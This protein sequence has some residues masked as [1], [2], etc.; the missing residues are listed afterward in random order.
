MM[1]HYHVRGE[2]PP[3]L[4]LHGLGAASI[5]WR[6]QV[7]DLSAAFQVICPDLRGFGESAIDS[8][9]A[10][11]TV[12]ELTSDVVDLL[13]TLRIERCSLVATSMGGYVA[14][15]MLVHHR[16]LVDRLVLCHTSCRRAVPPDLRQQ[17]ADALGRASSMAEFAQH[18]RGQSLGR[19]ASQDLADEV[20]AMLARN[21]FAYYSNLVTGTSLD[22]DLCDQLGS[23]D[24]PT[25]IIAG[26]DDQVIPLERQQELHSRLVGSR[27]EVLDWVGHLS[28]LEVPDRFNELVLGFL[29]PGHRP[30]GQTD[31]SAHPQ[32]DS[33]SNDT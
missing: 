10:A 22:F 6:Y 14:L 15:W 9:F 17:R 26:G 32:P 4:L 18:T 24:I 7:R 5:G 11:V 2:G 8:G 29:S 27:L 16:E 23:I 30:D 25:L 19:A 31:S 20:C 33:R 13:A 12:E 3:V 28:Y 1:L 21:D